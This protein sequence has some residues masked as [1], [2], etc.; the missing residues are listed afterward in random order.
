MS[1]WLTSRPGCFLQPRELWFTDILMYI[2]M[3]CIIRRT[4]YIRSER[5]NEDLRL[6]E[7][8]YFHAKLQVHRLLHCREKACFY[9]KLQVH[10]LQVAS[11]LL[12]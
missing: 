1:D 4:D 8:T 12:R 7:K 10:C 3:A 11:P 5:V 2:V 6:R 9:A